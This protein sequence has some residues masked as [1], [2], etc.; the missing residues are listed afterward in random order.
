VEEKR[1]Y[2]HHNQ[3]VL[4]SNG[5]AGAHI[6]PRQRSQ[7]F[8][9]Q[10]VPLT[11][12][13]HFW[14]PSHILWASA[15]VCGGTKYWQCVRKAKS[16]A[17]MATPWVQREIFALRSKVGHTISRAPANNAL[18][19]EFCVNL[20]SLEES[21]EYSIAVS[22]STMIH[23]HFILI[24]CSLGISSTR[25]VLSLT[26]QRSPLLDQ[27]VVNSSDAIF[28]QLCPTFPVA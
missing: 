15:S 7:V 2:A 16:V 1:G 13:G 3:L 21:Q 20:F 5:Y 28:Y 27:R 18:D 26:S 10:N 25:C 4:L 14:A 23:L 9:L 19:G 24:N 11:T 22:H 17:D 6:A 8:T 12:P